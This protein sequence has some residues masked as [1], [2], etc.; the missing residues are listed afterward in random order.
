M[1]TWVVLVFLA[2]GAD[3]VFI[4]FGA[5]Y[6]DQIWVYRV[7]VFVFPVVFGVAAWRMCRTLQA[8]EKVVA[9]RDEA[10]TEARLARMRR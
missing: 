4:L 5:S 6:I 2:G 3:R 10:E 9:A 1:I 8:S 7:I